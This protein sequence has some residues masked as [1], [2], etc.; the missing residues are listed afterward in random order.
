[1]KRIFY[2]VSLFLFFA[3]S[4]S[5]Q[6]S[7]WKISANGNTVYLAGS[8]HLLRDQDFPLPKEFDAA[9][10]A[11]QIL[12]IE[13]DIDRMEG[14][15]DEYRRRMQLENGQTLEDRLSRRTFR[16]LEKKAAELSLPLELIRE[17][18]PAMALTIFSALKLSK[19]GFS[20]PGVDLY[21]L[22]KAKEESKTLMYLE[23]LEAHLEALFASG[24][25]EDEDAYVFAALKDLDAAGTELQQ[26]IDE[27]RKG[28]G[29]AA[30]N[31]VR[32]MAEQYP[33]T[34]LSMLVNRNRA[35]LPL[36]ESYLASPE[37]EFVIAGAAHFYGP[38]GLLTLL[39][40]DGYTAEQLRP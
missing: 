10:D 7:V 11:S 8:V 31:T 33:Q 38:D 23:S 3:A 39:A 18:R 17:L 34:Y 36:I 16:L 1:M 32:E 4:V 22:E 35:W 14:L 19:L 24:Y 30:E 5:G 6:S 27:W 37:T 26:L 21:Y 29:H 25:F 12:V 13:T 15:G 20:R 9:F 40:A 28:I 2:L